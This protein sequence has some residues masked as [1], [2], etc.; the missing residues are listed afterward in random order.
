MSDVNHQ[1]SKT[2]VRKYGKDTLFI[3]EDLTG[4]SFDERNLSRTAKKRY[5]LRSWSFYQLEQFLKYKAQETGSE[6]LRVS[7]KYTSQR[8]PVCGRIHKQ[9]RDHN[10]HLYSCPCGYKS[11]DD[12]VGAMNIQNLGKRWLS[13]EKNPRYKKDNN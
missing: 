5:D 13:G 2:L 11:N 6:V 10:R 9:S 4:V 12:R 8:C 7:A 1:I 3:L